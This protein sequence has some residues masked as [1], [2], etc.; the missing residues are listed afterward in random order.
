MTTTGGPLPCPG[1]GSPLTGGPACPA[2]GL[3]LT[4]PVAGRL[5]AQLVLGEAPEMDLAAYAPLRPDA[6][7]AG[8]EA[9]AI[10]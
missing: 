3:P 9:D 7:A 4:G 2:C 8:R 1:C 6:S 10:R 5:L